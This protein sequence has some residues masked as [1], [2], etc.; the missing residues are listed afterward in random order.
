MMSP[1]DARMD[2]LQAATMAAASDGADAGDD[3]RTTFYRIAALA[4]A[5]ASGRPLPATPSARRHLTGQSRTRP[6]RLT[7]SW[8][9]CAEPTEGQ[10]GSL[11]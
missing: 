5:T 3:P 10:F 1:A 9:C 8:F 4:H 11:V 7:E 2:A 6:P